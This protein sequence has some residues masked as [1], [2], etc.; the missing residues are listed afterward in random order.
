MTWAR[1][2]YRANYERGRMRGYAVMINPGMLQQSLNI[3]NKQ[4]TNR[5]FQTARQNN[6]TREA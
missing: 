4:N 6:D 1:G 5:T 2:M 3:K